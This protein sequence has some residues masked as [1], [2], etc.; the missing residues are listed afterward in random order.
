MIKTT[1]RK[2]DKELFEKN[3]KMLEETK[4]R[5]REGKSHAGNVWLLLIEV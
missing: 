4:N 1:M 3:K 2:K 5:R